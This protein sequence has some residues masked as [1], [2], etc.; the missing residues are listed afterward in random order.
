MTISLSI[1]KIEVL[2][3]LP[4]DLSSAANDEGWIARSTVR[5]VKASHR[6]PE[7]L[8]MLANSLLAAYL[9][10]HPGTIGSWTTT[11]WVR[12][13]ETYTPPTA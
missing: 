3:P 2:R 1:I 9:E 12:P 6:S 10:A 5:T 8:E 13:F 4:S 11:S 7:E